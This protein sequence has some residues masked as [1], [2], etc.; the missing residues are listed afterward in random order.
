MKKKWLASYILPL[1]LVNIELG[2]TGTGKGNIKACHFP[3]YLKENEKKSVMDNAV[4]IG[5]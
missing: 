4:K 1:F 2:N 5:I 3:S